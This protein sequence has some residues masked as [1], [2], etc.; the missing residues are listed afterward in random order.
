MIPSLVHLKWRDR[1][2]WIINVY[3]KKD[4]S[5]SATKTTNNNKRILHTICTACMYYILQLLFVF[6]LLFM[7]MCHCHRHTTTKTKSERICL[8]LQQKERHSIRMWVSLY[9]MP[10]TNLLLFQCG[11]RKRVKAFAYIL[12]PAKVNNSVSTAFVCHPR[13]P[14]SY[15]TEINFI[16]Y[17]YCFFKWFSLRSH[18]LQFSGNVLPV[19]SSIEFFIDLF[20]PLLIRC[21]L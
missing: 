17:L 1:M 11:E 21:V 14:Y 13:H 3:V 4:D 18:P 19:S 16:C 20:V 9:L 10:N 8:L 2:H 12:Y 5:G 7:F 6:L 15:Q